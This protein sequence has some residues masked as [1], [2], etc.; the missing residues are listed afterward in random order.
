[1][2][3]Q[4]DHSTVAFLGHQTH[5]VSS[6]LTCTFSSLSFLAYLSFQCYISMHHLFFSRLPNLQV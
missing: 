6:R 1:M 5:L 3:V 2:L 4:K